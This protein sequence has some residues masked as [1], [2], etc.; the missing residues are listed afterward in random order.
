[1]KKSKNEKSSKEESEKITKSNYDFHLFFCP[2]CLQFPEY[3][4][5][6]DPLCDIS[7]SHKCLEGVIIN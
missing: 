3:E 2:F 7:L 5:N 6:I 1:M 4:I